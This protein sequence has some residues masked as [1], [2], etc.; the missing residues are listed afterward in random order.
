MIA[1]FNGATSRPYPLEEDPRARQRSD[2]QWWSYGREVQKYFVE[3]TI[4][5]LK[6]QLAD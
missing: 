2:F 5:D 4:A 6:K 3:H 1:C